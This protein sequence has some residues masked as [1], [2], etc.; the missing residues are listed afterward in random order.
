[1]TM[2]LKNLNDIRVELV[3]QREAHDRWNLRLKRAEKRLNT[4]E[5]KP[6]IDELCRLTQQ[7]RAEYSSLST[8][9]LKKSLEVGRNVAQNLEK[10]EKARKQVGGPGYI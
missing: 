8:D 10:R 9:E 4:L 3:R 6:L 7:S 1:M 5:R 2:K